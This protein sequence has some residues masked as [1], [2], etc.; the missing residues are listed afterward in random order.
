[1][2]KLIGPTALIVGLV[3]SSGAWA[4]PSE[5]VVQLQHTGRT[6]MI[7]API[8][9]VTAS[10]PVSY[11]DLNLANPADVQKLDQRIETAAAQSCRDLRA[12]YPPEF[13]PKV[14]GGSCVAS[15]AHRAE[16]AIADA[17]AN[18]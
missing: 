10:Q 5:P 15:A 16:A 8:D 18:N 17:A 6:S 1:M 4:A 9:E 11:A 7:G 12:A 13:Y 14:S 3:L 2:R